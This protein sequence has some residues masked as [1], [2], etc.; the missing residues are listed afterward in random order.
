MF[1]S[2]LDLLQNPLAKLPKSFHGIGVQQVFHGQAHCDPILLPRQILGR[3]SF[4]VQVLLDVKPKSLV[5]L[6]VV[7]H[8]NHGCQFVLPPVHIGNEDLPLHAIDAEIGQY[9]VARPQL[10]FPDLSLPGHNALPP[11]SEQDQTLMV[12]RWRSC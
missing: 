6:A 8:Q 9:M 7:N 11:K 5:L 12:A 3:D 1:E 2:S 10:A 4:L